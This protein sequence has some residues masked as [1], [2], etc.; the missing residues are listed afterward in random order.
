MVL[1]PHAAN[2]VAI[3]LTNGFAAHDGIAAT[4]A[5]NMNLMVTAIKQDTDARIR[6]QQQWEMEDS[7]DEREDDR[8][9]QRRADRKRGEE[10]RR[11]NN[12]RHE[13]KLLPRSGGG[14][15]WGYTN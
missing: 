3:V 9:D 6:L 12:K 4:H 8:R 15:M 2:M 5:V 7:D 11:E 1:S 10:R 13:L 14:Y